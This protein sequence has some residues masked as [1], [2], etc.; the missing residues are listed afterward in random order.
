VPGVSADDPEG[1]LLEAVERAPHDVQVRTVYADWLEERGDPRGEFLR[2][3]MQLTTLPERLSELAHRIDPAW[4]KLVSG[5]YRVTLSDAVTSNKIGLIKLVREVTGLG[6]KDAKDLVE[7]A[8]AG[9]PQMIADAVDLDRAREL[10]ALFQPLSAVRVEPQIAPAPPRRERPDVAF[11]ASV[12]EY[13]RPYRVLF[14][15]VA[16]DRRLDAIRFLR[17]RTSKGVSDVRDI[18]TA[19]QNG[20]P[21]EVAS[22]ID[23]TGAAELAV[24][25]GVLGT[26]KIE[27]VTPM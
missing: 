2:L 3:Q 27:R 6:L 12:R 16:P 15:A 10:V 26:A 19:I 5:T 18:V 8:A 20:T 21:F 13:L 14:V 25:L 7:R 1:A 24:E 17:E 4:M 23:A 22:H 9:T 11:Y